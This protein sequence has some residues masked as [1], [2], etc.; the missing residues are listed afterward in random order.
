MEK[1]EKL[2]EE[3]DEEME[4]AEHYAKKACEMRN[5]DSHAAAIY[6]EMAVQ[7]MGH[8]DNLHRLLKEHVAAMPEEHRKMMEPVMEWAEKRL[9][10][11]EDKVKHKL[12]M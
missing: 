2:M 6:N 1:F 3:I 4:G 8:A 7:E 9:S 11:W 5:R 10:R 12:K